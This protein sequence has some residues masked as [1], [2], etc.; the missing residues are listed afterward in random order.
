MRQEGNPK[1]AGHRFAQGGLW[2]GI[3]NATLQYICIS[4]DF[5]Y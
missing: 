2:T 4:Q 3:A 1:A 5:Q